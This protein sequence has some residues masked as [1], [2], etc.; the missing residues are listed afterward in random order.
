[1]T[2]RHTTKEEAW[3]LHPAD[4]VGLSRN[5]LGSRW[6]EIRFASGEAVGSTVVDTKPKLTLA[7]QALREYSDLHSISM[8]SLCIVACDL[9]CRGEDQHEG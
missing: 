3:P 4:T 2:G 6:F 8:D 1:M 9:V 5:V 7:K